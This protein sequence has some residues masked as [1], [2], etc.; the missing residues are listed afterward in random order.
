MKKLVSVLILT[1][2]MSLLGQAQTKEI[3]SK[4]AYKEIDVAKDNSA[5]EILSSKKRKQKQETVDAVLSNP[6]SYNPP[7][8]YALS[9]ELFQQGKKDD[10]SFWFYVA[11]LRAR[12]DANL[13]LDNSAKQAV[14]VLN[15]AYGPEINKYAFQ[16]M[17]KLRKM[18]EKVVEFVRLNEETYD[19]RWIN[20]H[21]MGAVMAGL[22]DEKKGTELS[23]PKDQ[24]EA[25]KKKTVDDYY[26]GFIE[27]ANS[28]KK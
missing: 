19:H 21:G 6:H 12:Y 22:G 15:N 18:V 11:Q 10:A 16:D 2:C 26:N 4:G 23:R 1:F 5:I 8:L 3:K 14:A 9:K 27:Y 28:Q 13:C 17:D 24:W 25:I 7:V 20:L